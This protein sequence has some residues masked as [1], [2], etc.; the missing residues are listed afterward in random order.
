MTIEVIK[1]ILNIV[2]IFFIIYLI[3]YSSFLFISVVIGSITLYKQKRLKKLKEKL[4]TNYD[5]PVSI[6]VPAHNEEITV[7]DTVNSLLELEY[8]KYEII[9]VD[10]GSKDSTSRKLI[11]YFEMHKVNRPIEKVIKCKQEE[12]VYETNSLKVPLTVVR[13]RNGGKADAL[14]M[15]INLSQYPYFICMDADSVLQYDSLKNITLPFREREDIVACGGLIRISND[16]EFEKGRVKKYRLP[17]KVLTA[18]QVL[19][20]DRSFFASRIM[21][22]GFNGNLIISGAFGLFKKEIVVAVGGYDTNTVGEDM[23]LVMKLHVFLKLNKI[24]YSIKYVPDAI[25]WSQAPEKLGD[26]IKQRRRW[27]IGLFQSIGKY[28]EM[29]LNMKFGTLSF[30]S[31]LYFLIYELLSPLI[32]ITGIVV[33]IISFMVNLINVNFMIIFFLLYA[34]F[35]AIL[36]LT[37]FLARVYVQDS[38]LSFIDFIRA[39]FLCFIEIAGLRQIMS[40]ARMTAFIGYKKRKL[41]WEDLTRKE[42]KITINS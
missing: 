27:H 7:I 35:G 12:Y 24:P 10:D 20:Y 30:I 21:L 4:E 37:I 42:Q 38:K 15:G 5:I 17:K 22:D 6:I 8:S 29:F 36:S 16:I 1:F 9:V 3:G 41:Q 32:E 2:E 40:I 34:A 14:N 33:T 25:C 39:L 23:E 11:E 19:E 18:M 13:K 26:L 31:Y 28:K